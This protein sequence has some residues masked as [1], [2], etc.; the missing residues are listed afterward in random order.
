MARFTSI[1]M[2]RKSFVASA[3]EEAQVQ[4]QDTTSDA[5]PSAEMVKKKT[6]RAGKKLQR[7]RERAE[8]IENGEGS[9]DGQAR[10]AEPGDEDNRSEVARHEEEEEGGAKRRKVQGWG[11]DPD[12]A[13][14]WLTSSEAAYG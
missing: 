4:N 1:G 14:E 5:G 8:A 6:H 11:R 9:A 3:A 12:I 13:R 10:A 2:P 7:K